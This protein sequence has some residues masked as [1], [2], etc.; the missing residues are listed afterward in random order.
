M[1]I[2]NDYNYIISNKYNNNFHS[3]NDVNNNCKYDFNN[4]NSNN[5]II[6]IIITNLE[7]TTLR[8]ISYSTSV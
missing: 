4:N 8:I 5:N 6:I 3:R 7:T 1:I 2:F